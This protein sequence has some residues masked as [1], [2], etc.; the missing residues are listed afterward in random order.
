M[1]REELEGPQGCSECGPVPSQRGQPGRA[2]AAAALSLHLQRH[3]CSQQRH[4]CAS[5]RGVPPQLL[6][7]TRQIC[8][9]FNKGDAIRSL[10]AGRT[11][12]R[13]R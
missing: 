6:I 1:N 3:R 11:A 7:I 12:P 9:G 2:Q 10:L 5:E 4:V 8:S 13:C